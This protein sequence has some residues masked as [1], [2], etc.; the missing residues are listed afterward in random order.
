MDEKKLTNEGT[1]VSIDLQVE[2]LLKQFWSRHFSA[3]SP[4][5]SYHIQVKC[6]FPSLASKPLSSGPCQPLQLHSHHSLPHASLVLT[7]KSQALVCLRTCWKFRLLASTLELP[8][9]LL[10]G[11]HHFFKRYP[12]KADA[13]YSVDHTLRSDISVKAHCRQLAKRATHFL[14]SMPLYPWGLLSGVAFIHPHFSPRKFL[15]VLQDSIVVTPPMDTVLPP[16]STLMFSFSLHLLHLTHTF[17]EDH[18]AYFSFLLPLSQYC[19]LSE[20]LLVIS[21]PLLLSR[22]PGNKCFILPERNKMHASSQ[23]P[24]LFPS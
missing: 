11:M 20:Q 23:S 1:T 21:W 8:I 19:M 4:L 15:L 9:P 6:K 10:G 2:I 16:P 17:L 22:V 5:R 18:S 12:G 24:V 7:Q 14:P 3:D 13:R